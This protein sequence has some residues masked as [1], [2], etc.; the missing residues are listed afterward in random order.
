MD[1]YTSVQEMIGHTPM[2]KLGHM[3]VPDGVNLYAK[4]E[5]FN[6]AGSVKDR[7]GEYMIAAAEKDGTLKPGGTIIEGTAGNTGIGIA[8]AALN[9][10]YR[11]I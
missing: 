10:G 4:L 6:P 9:K 3:E 7:V 8:I 11:V 1:V 2:L 5:L